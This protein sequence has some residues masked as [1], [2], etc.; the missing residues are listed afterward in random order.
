MKIQAGQFISS[1]MRTLGQK[2]RLAIIVI[3][4]SNVQCFSANAI[5]LNVNAG[6]LLKQAEEGIKVPQP[7]DTNKVQKA[8]PIPDT[9]ST[10]LK[11]QVSGFRFV[12]NTLLTSEQLSN[13]LSNFTNRMLSLAELKQAAEAVAT[14]YRE[15][16][17]TVRAFLPKQEV[18]N[19]IITIQIIEAVF[20]GATLQGTNPNRIEA[21]RLL[22]MAEA[23]LIKGKPLHAKKIDRALLLMDDLPGIQVTGNLIEGS[24]DGETDIAITVIDEDLVTGNATTDNQGSPSTGINRLSSNISINSP[25]RIGDS[26]VINALKT[27][28]VEYERI[29]Y[30]LP[31]GFDGWRLGA[32]ASTLKY[33]VIAQEF[34]A[35]NPYGTATTA[36]VDVNYPLLR[37]QLQ[38]VNLSINYDDKKFSNTSNSVA[39]TYDIK[40]YNF[41]INATQTDDW[42]G[43]GSTI[44]NI[45]ITTGNKST[46]ST[47]SKLNISLSR[48]Q[49]LSADLSFYASLNTQL[50]NKNLDSSEKIYLGG[51]TSVRAYPSSEA[52]GSEGGTLTFEI[53][54]R[55]AEKKTVTGFYDYGWA[56]ANHDNNITSPANPNNY[57]LRGYGFSL[58]WQAARNIDLKTTLSRRLGENPVA[59]SNGMDSDGTKKITRIWLSAGVAF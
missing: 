48:L 39:T 30:S 37:S 34:A 7:P 55:I 36:G 53:R 13:V 3:A 52:G 31:A 44:A 17:W 51:A 11:I 54:K 21:N 5:E 25:A 49:N 28:G 22:Q 56:R 33:Q 27:N 32:H 16:G 9:S 8:A 6:S 45:G 2:T 46:E 15:A 29:S 59:Q 18:D 35:L 24:H 12:G 58:N 19:E 42:R 4:F 50:S 41:S 47:F 40:A 38:N 43:G 10:D 1:L 14:A 23:N 26:L 20:G 57:S